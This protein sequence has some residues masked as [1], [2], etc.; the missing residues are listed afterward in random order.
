MSVTIKPTEIHTP[1]AERTGSYKYPGIGIEW[2][3]TPTV[4]SQRDR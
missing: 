4:I 3:I 1:E 2:P